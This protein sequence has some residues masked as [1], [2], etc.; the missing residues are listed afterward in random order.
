[1]AEIFVEEFLYRGKPAGDPD[2][3]AWHVVLASVDQDGFGRV[4]ITRN[5]PMG[6]DAATALGY[7]LPKILDAVNI[8]LATQLTTVQAQVVDLTAQVDAATAQI[9]VLQQAVAIDGPA[10]LDLPVGDVVAQPG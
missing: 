1:M 3:P 6:V 2:G 7:P 9:A 4:A 8:A 10:P 5:G